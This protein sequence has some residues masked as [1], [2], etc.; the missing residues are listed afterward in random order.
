MQNHTLTTDPSTGQ[1]L[2]NSAQVNAVNDG[3]IRQFPPP[4]GVVVDFWCDPVGGAPGNGMWVYAQK[5]GAN[6]DK[7]DVSEMGSSSTYGPVVD[8][9]A[10][11][12]VVAKAGAAKATYDVALQIDIQYPNHSLASST[13]I[14]FR[15]KIQ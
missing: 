13:I 8:Y 6:W 2:V 5:V 3:A 10:P 14:T 4:A 11:F 9:S 12:T 15:I 1:A 7:F